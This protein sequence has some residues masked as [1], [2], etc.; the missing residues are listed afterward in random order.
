MISVFD[1]IVILILGLPL[2]AA[3][4]NGLNMLLGGRYSGGVV[5]RLACGAIFL[6]FL[7]SLWVLAQVLLDPTPREVVV[8][9]WLFSGDLSVNFAFLIDSLSAVMMLVTT[10]ISFVIAVFSINYMHRERGFSRFFTVVPLFVFAMLVLVMANNYVLLFLGWESVGVCSYL[11]IGFY[12][13]RTSAAQAGTKAFVMNRVGDAGFLLGIFLIFTNFQTTDYSQ[14]FARAGTVDTGT[15]TAIGL[16]LLLGAVGKSAQLPLTTWLARAMEGPTPSSALIHAATMVTAGVYMIT[17]S[18]D[19]YD[20]APDALLAVAIVG[21]ATALF[22]AVVGLVQ[23]D[24]KSLLAYSTTTQL[25]LMFLACG[26]G[27][28]PVAI[29][30]LVAHA[31]FK[32]LLFL[33]SPSILHHLHVRPDVRKVGRAT[34]TVPVVYRLFL[35]GA[36]GLM[37]FPFLSVWWQSEVF[38]RAFSEGLYLLLALGAVA[39]FSA[40]F[41]TGR[42]VRVAFYEEAHEGHGT[43]RRRSPWKIVKPLVVLVVFVAI[44]LALGMLPGGVNGSWFQ[45]FL[46]PVISAQP[47]VPDG[48]L[49]LVFTLMGLMILLLSAG[50]F[51]SIHLDRFRPEQPGLL[52]FR[53]R[54]IYN[55]AL[56]RFWLDE[57]YDMAFVQPSKRL[58]RFF[59]RV[60]TELIDR[61]TGVPAPASR[62]HV[63]RETWEEQ[64]LIS[65]AAEA[66]EP[67]TGPVSTWEEEEREERAALV[68]EGAFGW[69]TRVS[70]DTS[71]QVERGLDRA[72]GVLGWLA[73]VSGDT[74]G[75]VEREGVGRAPGI[76][77][78]LTRASGDTSSWIERGIGRAPGVLGWLTLVSG[79]IS[80]RVERGVDRMPD[81]ADWLTELLVRFSAWVEKI[82]FT[83]VHVGVPQAGGVLGRALIKTEE[84]ISRPVVIG[85]IFIVSFAALL[86]RTLWF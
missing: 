16:C 20:R 3:L 80:T 8:Y 6:S 63:A 58:G 35:L 1:L 32:T 72:P 62:L 85:S 4:A 5:H 74:S 44:G 81:V 25:G 69:L 7:G 41:S 64:R 56:N 30:H 73:R 50:W 19:I 18:H 75:W 14:V 67:A 31:F 79:R 45:E 38:G 76:L 24:I 84:I 78:W 33:T 65:Q 23:T 51:A 2:L 48:G 11:L 59:E 29:F 61:A 12:Y 46:A 22:G 13:E 17:R 70:G 40:A 82:T 66:A 57:L 39:A 28:Y 37:A 27:A 53:M 54:R 60:D 71:S 36:V 49:P 9:R 52:F 21:A 10:G 26:F 55:L 68:G 47:G 86:I 77:G 34:E 42:M 43:G 15:L 83:G